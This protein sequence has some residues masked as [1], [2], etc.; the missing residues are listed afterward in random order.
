MT[1]R[2]PCGLTLRMPA[3]H[4]L[5]TGVF[6]RKNGPRPMPFGDFLVLDTDPLRAPSRRTGWAAQL[7]PGAGIVPAVVLTRTEPHRTTLEGHEALHLLRPL[8]PD[9]PGLSSRHPRG[10]RCSANQGLPATGLVDDANFP[11]FRDSS[12]IS[13]Q[14]EGDR[15]TNP[16]RQRGMQQL[17]CSKEEG[18][19]LT[20]RVGIRCG[21]SGIPGGYP[22][23][24][25]I[26][27]PKYSPYPAF[28][29][30]ER[31]RRNPGTGAASLGKPPGGGAATSGATTRSPRS[32]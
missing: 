1:R 16:K 4:R 24:R 30:C 26:K 11:S 23:R 18:P 3:K 9:I 15:H 19:S 13:D 21:S 6:L 14:V 32:C 7:G 29:R 8:P 5:K 10:S 17:P 25:P 27:A 28:G 31:T 20:L 2:K 12:L 22:T